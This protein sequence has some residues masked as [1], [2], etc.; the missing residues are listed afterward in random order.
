[1]KDDMLGDSQDWTAD[2]M[3]GAL[4]P[5]DPTEAAQGFEALR[6][7]L[8]QVC[9]AE[10]CDSTVKRLATLALA[11]GP[12]PD[13]L[14]QRLADADTIE[15]HLYMQ[16][17]HW[18]RGVLDGAMFDLCGNAR[19]ASM[20]EAL[21]P[22]VVSRDA[23]PLLPLLPAAGRNWRA[24]C[25]GIEALPCA[26]EQVQRVQHGQARRRRD[27]LRQ[28][29]RV[30]MMLLADR[31][32][33]ACWELWQ[34]VTVDL[35]GRYPDR[36]AWSRAQLWGRSESEL[37]ALHRAVEDLRFLMDAALTGLFAVSLRSLRCIRR[38][39]VHWPAAAQLCAEAQRQEPA[40]V[41]LK[42]WVGP[43]PVRGVRTKLST[44]PGPGVRRVTLAYAKRHL[45]ALIRE[46]RAGGKVFIKHR[47]RGVGFGAVLEAAWPSRETQ[48]EEPN[49]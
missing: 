9:A 49:A 7:F 29:Q 36:S 16:A 28:G 3:T 17:L 44:G 24:E 4:V 26:T 31:R 46:V 12:E 20:A 32:C 14:R 19:L 15:L 23:L 34:R 1:M 33:G 39:L 47:R 10:V 45:G 37:Q 8:I 18:G 5:A 25:L 30:L 48:G 21:H 38:V 42:C 13:A 40:G 27:A 6:E 35:L 2:D 11:S 43:A 41:W 22:R